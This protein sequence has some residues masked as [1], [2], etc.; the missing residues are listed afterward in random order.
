VDNDIILNAAPETVVAGYTIT[1]DHN[2]GDVNFVGY[3]RHP[4]HTSH[5]G[6]EY[7]NFEKIQYSLL[8]GILENICCK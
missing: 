6:P 5:F 7:I 8:F 1:L 4:R 3:F 2:S